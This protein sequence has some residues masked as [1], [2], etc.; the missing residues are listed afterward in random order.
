M[1]SFEGTCP[2]CGGS[3]S[4][5]SSDLRDWTLVSSDARPLK[6]QVELIQCEQCG[7]IYKVHTKAWQ[8][9]TDEIYRTYEI[10]H[11]SGGAEQKVRND[12]AGGLVSRSSMLVKRLMDYCDLPAE[13][14][15]L[16]FGCGNGAF[17]NAVQAVRPGCYLLVTAMHNQ[18]CNSSPIL[19]RSISLKTSLLRVMVTSQK[20]G[21]CW[22]IIPI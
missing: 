21:P 4:H 20:S 12:N 10:Y 9:T 17:L 15:I 16:D 3:D 13:G 18:Q 19:T 14:S 2:N 6:G 11:Q 8:D 5:Y 22:Q 1:A 7:H